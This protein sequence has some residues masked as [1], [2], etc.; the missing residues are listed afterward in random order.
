ME[1]EIMWL[2]LIV[3]VM[4]LFT[5]QSMSVAEPSATSA[6]SSAPAEAQLLLQQKC[7]ELDRLQQEI[8]QLRA[9]TGTPQQILVKVQMLEVG[10]TKMRDFGINT[11]WFANAQLVMDPADLRQVL[12]SAGAYTQSATDDANVKNLSDGLQFVD[13][14]RKNN[15]AKTLADPTLVVVSGKPASLHVGGEFPMPPANAPNAAINFRQFG[16]QLNVEASAVG[17]NRVSLNI[18]ARVSDLDNSNAIEMN[19]IRVPGLRVRE[20]DSGS[21]L[22]FGQSI[23]MTGLV[24][25]RIEAI[26]RADGE[27]VENTVDVGFMVVVTP[28]LAESGDMPPA[29]PSH[30]VQPAAYR[31]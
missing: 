26:E 28:E 13:W 3:V 31:Y 23:M 5:A 21:E 8:G 7:A 29:D 12:D 16:T 10:L 17:D 4:L 25:K 20:F 19:G 9:K 22:P 18:K 14:L 27:V 15:Y 6:P 24:Q 2:R 1:V 30:A 11:E